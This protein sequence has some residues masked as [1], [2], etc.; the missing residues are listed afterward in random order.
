MTE[1][2]PEFLST[3]LG[4]ATRGARVT[5]VDVSV[6]G[7]GQMGDCLRLTLDY[8]VAGAGPS[9]VV[10]KLPSGDENSR[11][12]AAVVRAYEIEVNFYRQL[13]SGLLVRSPRCYYASLDVDT[14]DFVLLLEDI[15]GGRQGDQLAG[16]TVDQAAAAVAELP[17]LHAPRWGDA[18][19]EQLDWLH[20]S[21]PANAG[22]L[23]AIVR[24]LYP[25]FLERYADRLSPDV[26]RLSD[27]VIDDLDALDADR[28]RPWTVAHN[29]YR[30][31]NL[32]FADA[33]GADPVVV[34]D[35][36]TCVY[37]PGI[38]DLAYFIGGSLPPDERRAHE[39]DLVRDYQQRM[40][41]A[42]V[43]LEW[44]DLWAQYRRYTVAGLIMAIAASMLVKRTPRGDDMF[45][46]MAERAGQHALDLF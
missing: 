22:M 20:R 28:P 38:S 6:V 36:Q 13:H 43:A 41:A 18:A 21:T 2:T 17:G 32:L 34:V 27:R 33:P 44:D 23:S 29:D 45:M 15:V 9:S 8:D 31:D 7:T 14:N 25:G 16:C 37:G 4:P 19:L 5:D 10:A 11:A 42:G 24:S 12:A 40:R 3:A 35:W 46:V 26:V 39:R 30:V 1:L